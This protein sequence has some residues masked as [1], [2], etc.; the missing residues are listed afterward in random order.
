MRIFIHALSSILFLTLGANSAAASSE[1]DSVETVVVPVDLA[2]LNLPDDVAALFDADGD[3]GSPSVQETQRE[4]FADLP[5]HARDLV[6]A[7]VENELVTSSEHLDGLLALGL[8]AN[9]FELVFSD[10]CILCHSDE[11]QQS[12]ETWMR[13]GSDADAGPSHLSL[14]DFLNGAHFRQ[15]LSCSGCHGG[16]ADDLDMPDEVYESWPDY[17]DRHEDRT[18]IPDFCGKCHSDPAFMRG[19]N[20]G[21]ATDQVAKYRT[22]GHGQKLL[23]EGDSAVAQCV[24]CHGVHGILGS[25]SRRSPVH[26]QAIPETCGRCHSD[27]TL[28]AGRKRAGGASLP[29]D[30]LTQYRDS[31]HGKALLERGDLGAPACNDCHGNHAAMPPEVSHVSQVCRTCHAMNGTL[32]DGSNHKKTFEEHQWPECETCHGK[33]NITKTFDAMLGTGPGELCHNCHAQYSGPNE[34][35]CISTAEH[36]RET[37]EGLAEAEMELEEK[38]EWM[39]ENGLDSE[40]LEAIRGELHDAL[41]TSRSTIHSF[42]RSDFDEVA[43]AG[44]DAVQRGHETVSGGEDEFQFRRKG[45][46]VAILVMVFLALVLGLKIREIDRQS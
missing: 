20:P 43:Q 25:D 6:A 23:G 26:P 12:E 44:L 18:W 28:M 11:D 40:S 15:G 41:R 33:H 14:V 38:Q 34:A 21:M 46:V 10:N 19:Y 22:S 1:S 8:D 5:S 42:N 7:A 9:K 24:S 35:E 36:F 16:A 4:Y 2:A 13:L 30:Q 39:A 37:V 45:L 17:D 27:A 29:T 31:V 32:F 3:D